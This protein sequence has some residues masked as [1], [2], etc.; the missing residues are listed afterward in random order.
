MN[1]ILREIVTVAVKRLQ[2]FVE[3]TRV[4]GED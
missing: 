2:I 1:A 4:S 3:I